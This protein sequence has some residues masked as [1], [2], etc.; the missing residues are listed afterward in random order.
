MPMPEVCWFCCGEIKVE[1]RGP[2]KEDVDLHGGDYR[3][4]AMID[5]PICNGL[6]ELVA[7]A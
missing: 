2:V 6:G 5:C 3:E 7:C 1:V 4:S